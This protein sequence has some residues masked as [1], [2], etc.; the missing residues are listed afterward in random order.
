MYL[1]IG[2]NAVIKTNSIVGV[3]DL[4]SS[5]VKKPTRSFL[6]SCEKNGA[7]FV[8]SEELPKSF[9]VCEAG[10]GFVVYLTPLSAATILKRACNFELS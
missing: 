5:T 4:D 2:Q 6:E 10:D 9:V 1:H 3:F 7:V 8:V